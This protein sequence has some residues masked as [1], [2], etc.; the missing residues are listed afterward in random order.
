M[1]F[2]ILQELHFNSQPN[3]AVTNVYTGVAVPW[4]YMDEQYESRL[5]NLHLMP[6]GMERSKHTLLK[7]ELYFHPSNGMNSFGFVAVDTIRS[8]T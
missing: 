3:H 6:D 4:P 1:N 2:Y 7:P 5:N 8:S